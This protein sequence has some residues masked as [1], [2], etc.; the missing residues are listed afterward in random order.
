MICVRLDG[1]ATVITE[2]HDMCETMD[3]GVSVITECA[4][5]VDGVI[6]PFVVS[7]QCKV[8][9]VTNCVWTEILDGCDCEVSVDV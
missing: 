9:P 3:G 7:G 4:S 8:M 1:G 5:F 6:N 2:C